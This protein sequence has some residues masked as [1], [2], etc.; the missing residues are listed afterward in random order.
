MGSQKAAVDVGR[1]GQRNSDHETAIV[2][3]VAW[4]SCH[5]AHVTHSK[6]C[7]G[8]ADAGMFWL[9]VSRSRLRARCDAS[10]VHNSWYTAAGAVV[11]DLSEGRHG[12]LVGDRTP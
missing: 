8:D 7:R 2:D 1:D 11:L 12:V 9:A 10:D 3:R 5:R 4:P 6:L